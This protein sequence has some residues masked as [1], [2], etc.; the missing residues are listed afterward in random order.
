M[1]KYTLREALI[2]GEQILWKI[3][4][5][6]INEGERDDVM[7]T[8]HQTLRHDYSDLMIHKFKLYDDD[9]QLYFEGLSTNQDCESAFQPLDWAMADAGCTDIKYLTPRGWE[10]L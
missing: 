6:H 9:G 8:F 10:S 1:P 3:T 2:A 5:D 4:K 7:P